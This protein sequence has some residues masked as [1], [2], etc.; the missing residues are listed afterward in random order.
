M[1]KRVSEGDIQHAIARV[2]HLGQ[3]PNAGNVCKILGIDDPQL[4]YKVYKKV[5]DWQTKH[6]KDIE[7]AAETKNTQA[8]E[9]SLHLLKVT[10]DSTQDGVLMIANDGRLLNWNQKFL[11]ILG[12]STLALKH[13][14]KVD[15]L[16]SA[17]T[18]VE[19]CD[20]LYTLLTQQWDDPKE[21]ESYGE[22]RCKGGRIIARYSQP[23]RVGK[24]LVGRVW[25]FRDITEQHKIEEALRLRERAIESSP[26]GIIMLEAEQPHKIIYINS[27]LQRITGFSKSEI[28]GK[29]FDVLFNSKQLQPGVISLNLA[30][31]ELREEEAVIANFTKDGTPVWYAVHI[32]PV[33]DAKNKVNHFVCTVV[34]IT[35]KKAMEDQLVH[36]ATHDALTELPNQ[37]LLLD[38]LQQAIFT[39]KRENGIVSILFVDLDQFKNINDSIGHTMGD[40]VLINVAQRLKNC[41]RETDTVARLGGDE[42]LIISCA[43]KKPEQTITLAQKILNLFNEPLKINN[44]SLHITVS[45]GI[46]IYPLDGK[47]IET[48]MKSADLAMYHAKEQGGNNF[49]FYTDRLNQRLLKRLELEKDL[50]QAIAEKQFELYY[51]PLVNLKNGKVIGSEALIRWMHPK[52]GMIPPLDF[53]PFTE[54][55]GLIV[56]IGEWVMKTA[57]QQNHS[58]HRKNK[59]KLKIAINISAVQLKDPHFFRNLTRIIE[60]TKAKPQDIELELTE[61][62]LMDNAEVFGRLL[63]KINDL[64]INLVIDDFGTGYSSLSYLRRFPIKKIK[65]DRSFIQ[66]VGKNPE[67]DIIVQTIIT[68]S[69]NLNLEVLAEGVETKEQLTFL[70][71]SGCDLAQGFYFQKPV[72]KDEFAKFLLKK[73][74]FW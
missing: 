73:H 63:N 24:T 28:I 26:H 68:M 59:A 30:L 2:V 14:A 69:K 23:H 49:A 1:R 40:Q 42:F 8:L 21:T 65:I 62:I 60:N 74:R 46:S 10:L 4:S 57:C 12:I 19:N 71:K 51:Q 5:A 50:R 47:D 11:D 52:K 70:L 48:L 18:Q 72:A 31:K 58:W 38:R 35:Q 27:A 3:E 43:Y 34:D 64:G 53:I 56:P 66:D 32:A 25:S 20:E 37:S 17:L 33:H 61:S 39:A 44:N 22:F 15:E 16:K 67:A 9:N 54:E 45:I 41:V 6:P 7:S 29:Q 13:G 55:S 36:Q